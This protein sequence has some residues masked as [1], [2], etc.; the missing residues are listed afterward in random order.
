MQYSSD[1]TNYQICQTMHSGRIEFR[2]NIFVSAIFNS[3]KTFNWKKGVVINIKGVVMN[4]KGVVIKLKDVV[5]NIK[6]GH[7]GRNIFQKFLYSI[8]LKD[9]IV[10]H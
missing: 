2:K 9:E 3:D 5:I 6:G 1:N 8:R 7:D 10:L 4:V